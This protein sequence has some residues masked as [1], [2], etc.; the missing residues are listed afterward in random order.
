MILQQQQRWKHIITSSIE[1]PAV[2]DTCLSL[3]KLGFTVTVLPVNEHGIVD[4]KA[5]KAAITEETILVSIMHV[6]NEIGAI[7]PMEE[8]G[9]I[10]RAHKKI[11]THDDAVQRSE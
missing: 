8:I 2:Y 4:V 9:E 11:L 10:V 3:E 7:Q 1:H 5:L 6:N